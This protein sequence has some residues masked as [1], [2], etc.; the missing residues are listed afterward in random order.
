MLSD[1]IS[2]IVCGE[3]SFELEKETS[4]N[5]VADFIRVH[6]KEFAKRNKGLIEQNE[7]GLTQNLCIFFNRN[8]HELPFFFQS[9][10]MEDTSR[11]NS[12]Q[13]DIGTFSKDE[14]ITVSDRIYGEEDSFFSMEAKRLPTPGHKREK[15]YVIG[16]GTECGGIERFKKCIHGNEL[17]YAAVIAY[18]QGNSFDYWF[19]EINKW[20]DELAKE[21]GSIWSSNDRL[22]G[23]VEKDRHFFVELTSENSR[24][25]EGIQIE[26]IYLFHF[27]VNLVP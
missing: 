6:F 15:E 26:N 23:H 21:N 5:A 22:K 25:K 24:F 4:I 14:K 27:W 20:I 11:G 7:T 1:R 9:E 17:K 8:S 2:N 18:V 3:L 10:Y 12:P 16:H 19:M 13:V